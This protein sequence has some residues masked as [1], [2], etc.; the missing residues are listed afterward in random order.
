[1]ILDFEVTVAT[2]EEIKSEARRVALEFFGL[3]RPDGH[4]YWF[5]IEG[6]TRIDP[7]MYRADVRA[8]VAYSAPDSRWMEL[9]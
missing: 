1:M 2:A 9:R 6:A 7:G 5:L 4:R 3:K 8:T